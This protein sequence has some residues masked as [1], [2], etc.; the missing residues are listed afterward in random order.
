MTT[1]AAL[2]SCAVAQ[3]RARHSATYRLAR[4]PIWQMPAGLTFNSTLQSVRDYCFAR[5]RVGRVRG[6]TSV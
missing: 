1:A 6:T 5:T 4:L 3:D 2:E